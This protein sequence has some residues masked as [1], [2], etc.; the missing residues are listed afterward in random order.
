MKRVIERQF[1]VVSVENGYDSNVQAHGS[2]YRDLTLLV[3]AEF[4]GLKLHRIPRVKPKTK[5][6]C[7]ISI[8]C[9]AWLKSKKDTDLSYKVLRSNTLAEFL[10]S[11]V[12]FDDLS[13]PEPGAKKF[14]GADVVKNGW[15]N[16]AKSTDF[17]DVD[18]NALL[19]ESAKRGW[20]VAGVSILI[21]ILG[22]D[23]EARNAS[24]YTPLI[25]AAMNGHEDVLKRLLSLGSCVSEGSSRL[26]S[27]AL[28]WAVE[29]SHENCVRV[30]L[31]A[32]SDVRAR[33]KVGKTALDYC[34]LRDQRINELLRGIEIPVEGIADERKEE[35]VLDE[36][37]AAARDGSLID[38][39]DNNDVKLSVVA[40]M[41]ATRAVVTTSENVF[42]ALWL[43]GDI[44]HMDGLGYTPLLH[45]ARFG[46]R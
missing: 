16:L 5:L 12:N 11:A 7:E 37:V 17:S 30:L 38:Y 10:S 43:G 41:L 25:Y 45:A 9:E 33:D 8:V 1:T 27:T 15:V 36:I 2:G 46:S 26:N 21:K 39:F 22:A 6:I 20:D 40:K 34:K 23:K 18:P 4:T 24:G 28:H 13:E 14:N 35:K 3:A 42:Q 32:R 19:W 44:E 29:N 31:A